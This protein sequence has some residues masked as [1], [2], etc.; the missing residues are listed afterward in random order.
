MTQQTHI[1]LKR[2]YVAERCRVTPNCQYDG[3]FGLFV[4][5]EKDRRCFYHGPVFILDQDGS[6]YECRKK[7]AATESNGGSEPR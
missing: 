3:G 6:Q 1:H 2:P 7:T 5:L 4:C